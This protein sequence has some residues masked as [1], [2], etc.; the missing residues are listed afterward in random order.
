MQERRVSTEV[1]VDG[2][3]ATIARDF[4]PPRL[5]YT[6]LF[7]TRLQ[8][9]TDTHYASPQDTISS[10][11]TY[12][13][14]WTVPFSPAVCNEWSMSG[15]SQGSD[16]HQDL[17]APPCADPSATPTLLC[18]RRCMA[19]AGHV[20]SRP[21]ALCIDSEKLTPANA[22]V[23]M[24]HPVSVPAVVDIV[25]YACMRFTHRV[26][27][28]SSRQ[29]YFHRPAISRELLQ[30][31]CRAILGSL[32]TTRSWLFPLG[33]NAST[34]PLQYAEDTARDPK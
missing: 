6:P 15:M 24:Y 4:W 27:C 30:Q 31:P 29:I 9:I 14:Q 22:S 25:C 2:D 20:S 32:K 28:P 19:S 10:Y 1:D 11:V 13:F 26:R 34:Q 3:R 18:H 12:N 8:L 5:R 23:L 21:R 33:P 17:I 16:C 7:S